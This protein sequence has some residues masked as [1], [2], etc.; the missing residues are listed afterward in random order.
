LADQSRSLT[1]PAAFTVGIQY[2]K[3]N[4]LKLGA[5][6]GLESWSGYK[7]EA[8]P[9]SL[10]NTFSVSGGMEYIPNHLSYNKFLKRLRYRAGA[11][12]RQDP[13]TVIGKDLNDIG[14][15]VGIG[16]PVVLPR[17]QTSFVN[18]SL[19]IGKLGTDSP[20][21]ETYFRFTAGFT[22]NDNSWFYKR[23]FE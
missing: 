21:E 15:T 7:N 14:F 8:R 11:Y 5:Q 18:L 3:A 13:R 17:Q 12:Y 16:L 4:K 23:R 22:L 1:L 19:E 9:E 20:I 10:R 2:V 6:V